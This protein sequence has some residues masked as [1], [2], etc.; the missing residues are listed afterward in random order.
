LRACRAANVAETAYT[1]E[2]SDTR[3]AEVAAGQSGVISRKQL[4]AAG[5]DCDA[6]AR[7]VAAGRLHPL[8]LNVFAVGHR[9]ITRHGWFTAALLQVGGDAALAYLS[10]NQHYD[11]WD[12]RTGEVQVITTRRPD[13]QSKL[14]IHTTS[15]MP[16][17]QVTRGLRVVTPP[18]ALLQ[19]AS[20]I[21]DPKT[22]RRAA[23]EAQVKHLTTHAEL[24]A[25]LE[26]HPGAR[27]AKRLRR[28][29]AGGPARTRNGGEDEALDFLRSCGLN[30]LTNVP[31]LGFEADFHLP[32]Q[33]LVIEFDGRG[34]HDIPIVSA[35]DRRRQAV[36]EAAG[37][38]VIR[39]DWEDLTTRPAQ[40]RRRLR[41]ATA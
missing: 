25:T 34:V 36:F 16:A 29:L 10:A 41:A 9:A 31:L 6:V 37:L 21:K 15:S 13:H 35:D 32:E 27:G 3:V 20:Q 23:R 26:R 7:R 5:L 28:A 11:V 40:T 30:P 18:I 38:R 17:V 24:L 2:I 4:A 22:I 14:R 1:A 19:L 8:F 12:G 33:K 39:I